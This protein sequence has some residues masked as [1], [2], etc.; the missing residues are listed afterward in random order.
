MHLRENPG[1]DVYLK[2][3]E[4]CWNDLWMKH[5]G[6]PYLPDVDWHSTTNFDL[7]AHIDFLRRYIDK[8]AMYVCID[9]W[10]NLADI[11]F[12]SR[13]FHVRYQ[14]ANLRSAL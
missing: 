11:V 2:R 12:Q 6:T 4:D 5:R 1:T 7:V 9:I 14:Q 8:V 10:H 3:L 13:W